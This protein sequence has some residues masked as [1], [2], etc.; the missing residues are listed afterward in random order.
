MIKEQKMP[1]TRSKNK[2]KAKS[3]SRAGMSMPQV[4]QKARKLGVTPGKMNKFDLIH[5]IQQAEHYYPCYGT[6]NGQCD[7]YDC[8][9]RADCLKV[10]A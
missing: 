2:T 8:C 5:A 10:T 1:A 7:N 6:S 3:G 4:K 9:F